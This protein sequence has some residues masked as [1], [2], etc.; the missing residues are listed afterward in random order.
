[1]LDLPNLDGLPRRF[2]RTMEAIARRYDRLS[3]DQLTDVARFYGARYV[4]TTREMTFPSPAR[5][6]FESGRFHLYDLAP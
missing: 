1:V 3:A 5:Q 2:D 6:V 4:V